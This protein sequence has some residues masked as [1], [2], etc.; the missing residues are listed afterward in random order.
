M[1]ILLVGGGAREHTIA[2]SEGVSLLTTTTSPAIIS[3][4]WSPSMA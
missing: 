2:H 4:L 1:N 3:L